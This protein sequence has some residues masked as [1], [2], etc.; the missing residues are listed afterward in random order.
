MFE[1]KFDAVNEK[2]LVD[3]LRL[4]I[5]D[6][7]TIL[8]NIVEPAVN[9]LI[10]DT[11]V[12]QVIKNKIS[13]GFP[14]SDIKNLFTATMSDFITELFEHDYGDQYINEMINR[15][16]ETDEIKQNIDRQIGGAIDSINTEALVETAITEHVNGMDIDDGLTESVQE[17]VDEE[18]EQVVNMRNS[19]FVRVVESSISE[20]LEEPQIQENI[21]NA[22]DEKLTDILI[23]KLDNTTIITDTISNKLNQ[24]FTPEVISTMINE[25]LVKNHFIIQQIIT[26]HGK[27]KKI[28]PQNE[29]DVIEIKVFK[30]QTEKVMWLLN[31]L[32]KEIFSVKQAGAE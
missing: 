32:D 17:A 11:N 12:P 25:H 10:S 30:D 16:F 15:H 9:G 13:E 18:V 14:Q 5:I 22:V 19:E 6:N 20:M 3:Y 4:M 8:N 1:I 24:V 7:P 23:A 26:E 29:F 2:I 21:T 27:E 31:C 28:E